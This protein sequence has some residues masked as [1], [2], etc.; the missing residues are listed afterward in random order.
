MLFRTEDTQ[1][2]LYNQED[3][4]LVEFHGFNGLEKSV[5]N[6]KEFLKKFK[7]SDNPFYDSIVYGV[8]F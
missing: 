6:F 3:R 4:S 7:D 5:E 8:I 2:K 1:P